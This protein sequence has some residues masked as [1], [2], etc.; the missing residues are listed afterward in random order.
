[1]FEILLDIPTKAV[2]VASDVIIL[3]KGKIKVTHIRHNV[4]KMC[5][6]E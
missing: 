4:T 6:G 1:M 3:N 2:T 5:G